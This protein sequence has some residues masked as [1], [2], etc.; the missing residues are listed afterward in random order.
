MLKDEKLKEILSQ[1]DVIEDLRSEIAWAYAY[2]KPDSVKNTLISSCGDA[3]GKL[4]K[5]L[6]N[7]TPKDFKK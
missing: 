2:S 3:R 4:I 5:L 1:V 6:F 7:L